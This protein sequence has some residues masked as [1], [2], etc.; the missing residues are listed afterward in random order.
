MEIYSSQLKIP[1]LRKIA[2]D[3]KNNPRTLSKNLKEAAISG[4]IDVTLCLEAAN[5]IDCIIKDQ[6]NRI[7]DTFNCDQNDTEIDYI[8]VLVLKITRKSH[9]K[10]LSY[11]VKNAGKIVNSKDICRECGTT[12]NTFKV[13][14]SH[15]RSDL[16]KAGALNLLKSVRANSLC[17]ESGYIVLL[18]ELNKLK[19][20]VKP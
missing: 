10:I 8:I 12:Q 4:V 19:D 2:L 3:R 11:L 1:N 5:F 16:K 20:K 17:N 7:N 18:D 15:L 13:Q 14:M 9:Q 6:Q